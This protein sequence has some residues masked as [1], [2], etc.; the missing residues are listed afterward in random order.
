[1]HTKFFPP[2]KGDVPLGIA[3]EKGQAQ[4]VQRLL[5]L[6]ANVNHKNKVIYLSRFRKKFR[7]HLP[8]MSIVGPV[9]NARFNNCVFQFLA[10]LRI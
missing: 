4:T 10:A 8:R 5:K 6:G 1:M 7:I 2:Q 9:L 3:V